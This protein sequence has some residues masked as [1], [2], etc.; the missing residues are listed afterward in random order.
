M[1]DWDKDSPELRRNLR[2]L[3]RRIRDEARARLPW[4]A[5]SG[6]RWHVAIMH[7]LDVPAGMAGMFRG[8]PGL[9][10]VEVRVGGNAGVTSS[11]VANALVKFDRVL[12]Q[13]LQ[14]LDELVPEAAHPDADQLAAVLEVCAWVHAEWVRIHPFANGNGRTARLWANGVAM[15]YGLPPFVQLR[16]RPRDEYGSACEQAMRGEWRGTAAVFHQMLAETLR[17][18]PG[19]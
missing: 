3:L 8:E 14:Q 11:Q 10:N 5:E 12:E 4:S 9:E 7:E 2:N 16:P 13:V 15:R 1:P 6:R 17:R 18:G 19:D